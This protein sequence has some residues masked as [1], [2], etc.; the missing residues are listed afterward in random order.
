MSEIEIG[1]SPEGPWSGTTFGAALER[2]SKALYND[3]FADEVNGII[4]FVKKGENVYQVQSTE[5][6]FGEDAAS[7]YQIESV[8]G[9][10]EHLEEVEDDD[11]L[12]SALQSLP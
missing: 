4:F 3:Q 1:G 5:A 10:G 8:P 12:F 11:A 9:Q 6:L 2:A 7:K